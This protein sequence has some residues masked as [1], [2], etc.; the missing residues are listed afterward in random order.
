MPLL[1]FMGRFTHREFRTWVAWKKD[2]LNNPSRS[3]YY[4]MRIAGEIHHVMSKKAWNVKRFMIKFKIGP[5]SRSEIEQE[6]QK[7]KSLWNKRL[8]LSKDKD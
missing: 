4:L 2:Q 5:S 7:S 6:T 3:D 1:E 8:G